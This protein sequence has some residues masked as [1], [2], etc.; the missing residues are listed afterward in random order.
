MPNGVPSKIR[1]RENVIENLLS[2]LILA[3]VITA[4]AFAGPASTTTN[5]ERTP[6]QEWPSRVHV[7]GP[8]HYAPNYDSCGNNN[9]NPDFQLGGSY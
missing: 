5:T 1:T 7:Y 3:A 6:Q 8:N 9:F 4:P 2:L